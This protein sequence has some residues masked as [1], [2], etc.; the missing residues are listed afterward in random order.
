MHHLAVG[1]LT[2]LGAKLYDA[3]LYELVTFLHIIVGDTYMW[4]H[5]G[6]LY[7]YEEGCRKLFTGV[8]PERI[9]SLCRV[10]F[11]RL[12]GLF[13]S[14]PPSPGEVSDQQFLDLLEQARGEGA[15]NST[16]ELLVSWR[17]KALIGGNVTIDGGEGGKKGAGNKENKWTKLAGHLGKVAATMQRELLGKQLVQYYCEWCGVPEERKPGFCTPDCC[18]MFEDDGKPY[19]ADKKT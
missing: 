9:V 1:A 4:A 8:M 11:L 6:S 10:Y 13:L 7:I 12:E 18:V 3:G 16:A 14:L 17:N 5:N 19:F 2:C 15:Y